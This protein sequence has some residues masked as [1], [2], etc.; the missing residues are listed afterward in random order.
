MTAFITLKF[1]VSSFFS[2]YNKEFFTIP[3]IIIFRTKEIGKSFFTC[4]FDGYPFYYIV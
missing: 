2:F 3:L 4:P 1:E